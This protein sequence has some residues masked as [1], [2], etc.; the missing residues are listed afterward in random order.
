MR[1]P[2]GAVKKTMSDE[3]FGGRGGN[4]DSEVV[5]TNHA[6]RCCNRCPGSNL[7]K[8]RSGCVSVYVFECVPLRFCLASVDSGGTFILIADMIM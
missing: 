3:V 2:I 8:L 5:G 7:G 1:L 4:R 6:P